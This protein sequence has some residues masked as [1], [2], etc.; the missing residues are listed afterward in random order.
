MRTITIHN[1]IYQITNNDLIIK[2]NGK[3]HIK[4]FPDKDGYL[5]YAFGNPSGTYN[6]TVHKF[7]WNL[8]FG[9]VPEGLTIDHKDGN[10]LNN[11]ISNLQLLTSEENAVKG[12]ARYWLV[13]NPEGVEFEVYNLSKFCRE[14]GLHRTHMHEVARG[15]KNQTQHNGWKC[16]ELN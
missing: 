3:G 14:N 9:E 5:K 1:R 8:Y 6:I 15:Y 11:H 12:N 13:T 7:V 4:S 2:R 10:K 16:N